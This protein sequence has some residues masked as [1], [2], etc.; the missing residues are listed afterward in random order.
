M[1]NTITST[2]GTTTTNISSDITTTESTTTNYVPSY[3]QIIID[4]NLPSTTTTNTL[5]LLQK[6][7]NECSPVIPL[8]QEQCNSLNNCIFAADN[9]YNITLDKIGI[10]T[11]TNIDCFVNK[12]KDNTYSLQFKAKKIGLIFIIKKIQF[13]INNLDDTT[14]NNVLNATLIN[15]D[16]SNNKN[17]DNIYVID[18]NGVLN[19]K[20]KINNT[21]T[22]FEFTEIQLTDINNKTIKLTNTDSIN[23]I[24]NSKIMY[25]EKINKVIYDNS[26][27]KKIQDLDKQINDTIIKTIIN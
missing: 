16:L 11:N 14:G 20:F 24:Y 7:T 12:N 8:G 3:S 17:K 18:P 26:L 27:A 25:G 5:N 4:K 21:N 15:L 13:V 2:N 23:K 1:G 6:N 19:I 10:I 9:C 22:N